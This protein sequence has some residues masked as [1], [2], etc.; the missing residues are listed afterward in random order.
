MAD[1]DWDGMLDPLD[2]GGLGGGGYEGGFEK[3][4]PSIL[5]PLPAPSASAA[6]VPTTAAVEPPVPPPSW[7]AIVQKAQ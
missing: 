7:Q 2:D 3:S 5:V 1:S 6:P 4:S